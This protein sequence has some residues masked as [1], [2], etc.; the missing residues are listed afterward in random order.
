MKNNNC[1][2][3]AM[4]FMRNKG[5]KGVLVG[6]GRCTDQRLHILSREGENE[7]KVIKVLMSTLLAFK[8]ATVDHELFF[9]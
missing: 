9:P 6:W 1:I 4:W 8:S 5:G 2:R 7:W 3:H